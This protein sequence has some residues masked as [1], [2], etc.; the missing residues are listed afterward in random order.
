MAVTVRQL[1]GRLRRVAPEVAGVV[2]GAFVGHGLWGPLDPG[3]WALYVAFVAAS[4][5]AVFVAL[6]PAAAD[7]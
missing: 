7:G 5:L 1:L 3:S 6:G 4:G 2:A